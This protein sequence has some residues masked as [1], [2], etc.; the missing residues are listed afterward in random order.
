MWLLSILLS[1]WLVIM[2]SNHLTHH[3]MSIYNL[4]LWMELTVNLVRVYHRCTFRPRSG[5]ELTAKI[6]MLT[7]TG[8][9]Q[10]RI[11]NCWAQSLVT[12]SCIPWPL[13]YLVSHWDSSTRRF[14][15]VD[16]VVSIMWGERLVW[17]LILF[18]KFVFHLDRWINQKDQYQRYFCIDIKETQWK[19]YF[20]V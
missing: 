15:K 7:D 9:N 12:G 19:F 17:F 5:G 13:R 11:G 8:R 16:G 14:V 1:I 6:R 18:K 3:Q 10:Q 20:V 4:K 2:I